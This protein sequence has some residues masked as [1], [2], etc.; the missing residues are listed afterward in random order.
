VREEDGR[1]KQIVNSRIE[2]KVGK[3]IKSFSAV[4]NDFQKRAQALILH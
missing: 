3:G 2:A 4:A 1:W